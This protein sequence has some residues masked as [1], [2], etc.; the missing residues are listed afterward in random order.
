MATRNI[1]IEGDTILRKKSRKI[2]KQE[3]EEKR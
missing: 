2:E 3:C 1:V